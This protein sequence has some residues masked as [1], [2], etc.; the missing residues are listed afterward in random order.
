MATVRNKRKLLS[1]EGK[2]KSV[3]INRKWKKK[4]TDV[5]REF[6]PVNSTNQTTWGKKEPK[7]LWMKLFRKCEQSDVGELL[8]KCLKQSM[9]DNVRVRPGTHCPHVTWA[10]GM[11]R[12][13]LGYFNIEFWH[14]HT[15][16]TL[17]NSHDL[18]WSSGWFTC[19]HAPQISVVA[20]ISWNVTYVSSA[21][22]TLLPA[23]FRNGG[24]A[25]WKSAPT[26]LFIWHQVTTL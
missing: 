14:T 5:Y 12:V 3:M 24:N 25:Y 22:Q 20:H 1:V 6:C 11:L 4:K 13:H 10:H 19:Q 16:V 23:V 21:L 17:L 18:T 7:L 26:D 9:S 2:I 8:L 15:S